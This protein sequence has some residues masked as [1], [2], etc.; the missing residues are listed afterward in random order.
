MGTAIR[1]VNER[2]CFLLRLGAI[3]CSI[4]LLVNYFFLYAGAGES[5]VTLP[6]GPAFR[7]AYSKGGLIR[8]NL[9]LPNK[10]SIQHRPARVKLQLP[11]QPSSLRSHSK[12]PDFSASGAWNRRHRTSC[13]TRHRCHGNDLGARVVQRNPVLGAACQAD[14]LAVGHSS[15]SSSSPSGSK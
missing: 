8:R 1:I 10:P 7:P 5:L 14:I 4:L 3:I 6:D 13:G 9:Q 2:Y 11:V 12:G 15:S